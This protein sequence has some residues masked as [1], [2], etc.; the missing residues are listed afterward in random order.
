MKLKFEIEYIFCFSI[1]GLRA[2]YIS[3]SVLLDPYHCKYC[4]NCQKYKNR[5]S[6][7]FIILI[8]TVHVRHF[9]TAPDFPSNRKIMLPIRRISLYFLG[10]PIVSYNKV[11]RVGSH[12]KRWI[13]CFPLG[14]LVSVR[15]LQVYE[16]RIK[17]AR[18]HLQQRQIF[19]M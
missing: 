7:L 1:C 15:Q 10:K 13:N 5:A 19:V 2:K 16:D 18:G 17:H 11:Q 3:R 8:I 4:V 9:K 6:I 12:P 14:F